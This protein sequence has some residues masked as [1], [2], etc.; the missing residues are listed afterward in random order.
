MHNY[1]SYLFH[2]TRKRRNL[3]SILKQGLLP[4]Y[5]KEEFYDNNKDR[6][7]GIPMVSFCDIPIMRVQNFSKRYGKYAIAFKKEWARHNHINPVFY[8]S[9]ENVTN[10]INLFKSIEAYYTYEAGNQCNDSLSV[11]FDVNKSQTFPQLANFIRA[12]QTKNAN[13][14]I[15]GLTKKYEME[16]DGNI[17]NNYEENEWRY[18]VHENNSENIFWLKG[19][20]EYKKW[21]G[22]SKDKPKPD[23][24][25]QHKKLLFTVDDITHLIT[26][27]ESDADALIEEI[28]KIKMLCDK[29][30]A[31]SEKQ[32]LI[33]KIISFERIENDF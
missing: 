2:Y 1:T 14:T 33:R 20:E 25:L 31:D 23:K 17:Q 32:K 18:V 29:Q 11:K 4:N 16:R 10:A 21:R 13:D 5:C 30:I 24:A 12:L 9:D 19:E 8:I 7:L 28:G 15:F 27:K 22:V 6:I 3:V 26:S